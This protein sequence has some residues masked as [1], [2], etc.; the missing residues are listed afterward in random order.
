[1][2]LTQLQD[3][4]TLLTYSLMTTPAPVQVS[5]SSTSPSLATLTYVVSCPRSVGAVNIAQIIIILPVDTRVSE[6]DPTNLSAV[7]PPKSSASISSTGTDEWKFDVGVAPNIFIFTPK[8]DTPVHVTLQS[9]TITFT[10]IQVNTLVG[11]ALVKLSE[12]A[13]SGNGTP[14][15]VTD[16]P[17]GTASIAVPKFPYG[18]FAG[19][20]GTDKPM[21]ENSQRPTLTWVG[22]N[23]ATYKM[24]WS[25][26]TQDVSNIRSWSALSNP[27]SPALTDTTT[28]ILQV[29]AQEG[30]QTV[31]E[32][33]SLTVVVANPSFTARDLTVLTSSA[34]QGTATIG[35]VGAPANLVVNKNVNATDITGTGNVTASKN[36]SGVDVTAS[37]DMKATGNVNGTDITATGNLS[38]SKNLNVTGTLQLADWVRFPI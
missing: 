17:S 34:L 1:M 35:K 9:L 28:F 32:Y 4:S 6:P 16:V 31:T 8:N 27:Q 22:S 13:A 26:Q 33:F 3:S 11:T 5:P 37:G 7:A 24:L 15:P 20:L 14:P 18:F 19:N 25:T 10:G 36:V 23:N 2:Q 38:A 29:T 21:I 12:W 30:R